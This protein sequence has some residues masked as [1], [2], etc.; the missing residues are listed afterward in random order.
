MREQCMQ[1]QENGP[2]MFGDM[3]YKSVLPGEGVKECK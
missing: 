3:R 2:L 1:R